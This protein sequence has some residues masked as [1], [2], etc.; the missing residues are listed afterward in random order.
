MTVKLT[1]V[2]VRAMRAET[3]DTLDIADTRGY[4]ELMCFGRVVAAVQ[5]ER[6]QLKPMP[7][8]EQLDPVQTVELAASACAFMQA[9]RKVGVY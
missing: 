5:I 7:G 6:A 1:T 4:V 3:A 2:R 8:Y 9:C